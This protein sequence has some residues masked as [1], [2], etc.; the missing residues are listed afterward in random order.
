MRSW[1]GA[2]EFNA[3][4][5]F[6]AGVVFFILNLGFKFSPVLASARGALVFFGA[7]AV[8]TKKFA[9]GKSFMHE[10]SSGRYDLQNKVAIVTGAATGIG[11]HTVNQLARLGATVVLAARGSQQ[12]LDAAVKLASEGVSGPGRVVA[13]QLDLS[14][15]K[16]IHAFA[17]EFKSKFSKLHLLVNN[18]GVMQCPYALTED[19]LEMQI[20]TN[21]FGHF[22]L[23]HLL[24]DSLIAAGRHN[25]R[26]VNVSSLAHSLESRLTYP[27][28]NNPKT[29][30]RSVAYSDS[31]LA[32]VLFTVEFERRYGEA[33]G[34]HAYSLHPGFVHTELARHLFS[35]PVV[36]LA[37]L[38]F[39]MLIMKNSLEG[40]QTSLF[41]ALSDGAVPGGYHSDAQPWAVSPVGQD[42]EKAKWL[43]EESERI[44]QV[45]TK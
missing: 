36:Q 35:T 43:W 11:M 30:N 4:C 28:Q 25:A 3:L 17:A 7:L 12:R 24:L 39:Q 45:K 42:A 23:T 8:L 14:S 44:C 16:S 33:L 15:F 34:I 40:A 37:A 32:N 20:G 41:C 6:A 29:Y 18:A 31:K 5:T 10:M 9:R 13:M 22:L 26:V 2:A 21:H 1:V 38:P 27:Q 19:G